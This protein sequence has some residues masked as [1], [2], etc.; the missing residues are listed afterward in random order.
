M[1]SKL[2]MLELK[3]FLESNS[4]CGLAELVLENRIM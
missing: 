4:S 1:N 2:L 3:L